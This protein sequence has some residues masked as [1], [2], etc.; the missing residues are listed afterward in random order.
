MTLGIGKG[1]EPADMP[2]MPPGS[3]RS[4]H[5]SA[6][7]PWSRP[8]QRSIHASPRRR[9]VRGAVAHANGLGAESRAA[10]AYRERGGEILGERVRTPAGEI[11]LIVALGG[12]IVFVEVKVRQN[13]DRAAD[14]IGQRQKHRLGQAA[15]MWLGQSGRAGSGFRFDAWLGDRHGNSRLVENALQFD[16]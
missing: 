3:L 13:L 6:A 10:E 9:A 1:F 15:E 7:Q 4:V 14:A 8:T 5:P 11:D 2:C 16:A 12:V